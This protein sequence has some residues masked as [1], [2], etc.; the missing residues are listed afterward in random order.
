M[1]NFGDVLT[2]FYCMAGECSE[3]IFLECGKCNR[4]TEIKYNHHEQTI[5]NRQAAKIFRERGW[6][7]RPTRRPRHKDK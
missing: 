6:S 7:I 1:A 5:T 3:T 4:K 2:S